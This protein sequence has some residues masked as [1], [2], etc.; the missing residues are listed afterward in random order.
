MTIEKAFEQ[1][2]NTQE[3]KDICKQRDGVGSKYRTYRTRFNNMLNE[4]KGIRELK[5]GAIVEMLIAHGYTIT[6]NRAVKK[7]GNYIQVGAG[8]ENLKKSGN[9]EDGRNRPLKM[10]NNPEDL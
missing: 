9:K 8:W 2:I 7:K 10:Y 3:Y 1:L 5:A 6:A 4:A